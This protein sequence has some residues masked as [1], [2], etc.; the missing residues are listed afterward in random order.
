MRPIAYMF[1]ALAAVCAGIARADE[2]FAAK[3]IDVS[4]GE[5]VMYTHEEVLLGLSCKSGPV[6]KLTGL[7]E[8]RIGDTLKQGKYSFQVGII[9]V[10]KY[11]RD[12]RA[13]NQTIAKKGET[14]CV[15][16]ANREMLPYEDKCRAV[17]V[18]I[19]NCEP[20]D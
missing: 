9:E 10:T 3:R 5:V 4:H 20:I 7:S 14:E 18:R 8:I 12:I 1:V 6:G 19:T 16:A 2:T 13:G 15:L 17:W 11:S